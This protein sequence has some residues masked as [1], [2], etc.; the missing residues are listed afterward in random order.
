MIPKNHWQEA[1]NVA[2]MRAIRLHMVIPSIL[3]RGESFS[4]RISVIGPDGLP[5]SGFQ[6]PL[7]FEGSVGIEGLPREFTLE[8]GSYQAEIEGLTT[9]DEQVALVRARVGNTKHLSG[10]PVVSSNPAWIFKDPPYR[11]F[12]GDIHVHTRYSNCHAWRCL[13]PEW[14]YAYARDCAFL[15]FAAAADHLRGIAADLGRWPRLQELVRQYYEPARFVPILSYESSHAQGYGGDNN[16]YFKDDEA[17]YFW[18]ERDDMKGVSPKVHL[19]E[20]WRQMDATGKEYLTIPHHTARMGKYRAWDEDYYDPQR[21]PLFE[22]YSTW[23]SSE[24]RWNNFPL[25][26]GNNDAPTYYVDALRAGTRY[27]VIASSDDHAT[28]PGIEHNH[29]VEPFMDSWQRSYSH[30][31]LA[32]VRTR[33]L[34][35]EDLFAALKAR[36]TYGTTM[37]RVPVEMRLADA[38]MGDVIP[39]DKSLQKKRRLTL[40]TT[41]AHPAG[42]TAVLLRNG[43]EIA[44]QKLQASTPQKITAVFEDPEDFSNVS[45]KNSKFNPEPFVVYYFRLEDK[46]ANTQWTS[47]IWVQGK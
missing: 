17:P 19:R 8:N 13:D 23:G 33:S 20:L 21:E 25:S 18:L 3:A 37:A 6:L 40:E 35:R 38:S 45:L 9:T 11:I 42:L 15:D 24:K 32:A 34:N 47:P 27:G 1:Y 46:M 43:E 31:G 7:F 36:R 28:L 29:R 2:Y 26:G 22:I 39:L 41:P 12:W 30:T 44:S 5:C 14:M 10:D 4:L 16:V